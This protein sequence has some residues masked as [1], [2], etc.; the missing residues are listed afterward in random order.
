MFF[1][2][3][4]DSSWMRVFQSPEQNT[5][6]W[7]SKAMI[8]DL[9][10]GPLS[11]GIITKPC[12]TQSLVESQGSSRLVSDNKLTIR[13]FWQRHLHVV[14]VCFIH[15]VH[16]CICEFPQSI[17]EAKHRF[18]EYYQL[19]V[20]TILEVFA[21]VKMSMLFLWDITQCGLVNRYQSFEATYSLHL[22]G[23]LS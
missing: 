1:R 8:R 12:I 5:L 21:A 9:H 22:Q 2:S 4:P 18:S 7:A 10:S 14:S 3:V 15:Q 20:T 16:I 23:W 11:I 6:Q 13:T 17:S 19:C